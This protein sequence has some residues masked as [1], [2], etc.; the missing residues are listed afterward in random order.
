MNLAIIKL[1]MLEKN[2]QEKEERA[3]FEGVTINPADTDLHKR[4][5][6]LMERVR[7]I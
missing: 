3:R 4:I 1:A 2:L 5:S 6:Y 7:R